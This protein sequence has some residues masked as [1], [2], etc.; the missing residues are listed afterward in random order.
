[1]VGENLRVEDAVIDGE[2]ACVDDAGRSVL[3]DPP[4]ALKPI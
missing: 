4:G 2:I 3:N 1:M